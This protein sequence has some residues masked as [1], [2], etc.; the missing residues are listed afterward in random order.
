MVA[1]VGGATQPSSDESLANA[2]EEKN[3][4]TYVW[5]WESGLSRIVANTPKSV[6]GASFSADGERVLIRSLG[7]V[8]KTLE[9]KS[10]LSLGD[11]LRHGS[12]L[13]SVTLRSDGRRALTRGDPQWITRLELETLR[14]EAETVVK[15]A[16]P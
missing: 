3:G 11:P 6:A 9:T 4:E 13:S 14:R 2:F 8:A 12:A 5:A 16:K 15:E 1:I 7:G 10:G